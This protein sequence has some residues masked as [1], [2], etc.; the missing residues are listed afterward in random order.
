MNGQYDTI[1]PSEKTVELVAEAENTEPYQLEELLFE[2]VDADAL[3]ALF[4]SFEDGPTRNE[5][6]VRFQ[7]HG[8]DVRVTAE[9]EVIIRE[10]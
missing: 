8:Y 2:T 1:P 9:D 7:Y 4:E 10:P 3:D 6:A 5:G